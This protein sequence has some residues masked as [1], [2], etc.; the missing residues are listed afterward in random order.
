MADCGTDCKSVGDQLASG[1]SQQVSQVSQSF[2]ESRAVLLKL[3]VLNI[4]GCLVVAHGHLW[5]G[6][7]VEHPLH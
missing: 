6:V 4:Q 2:I 7:E 1:S 5:P 3:C